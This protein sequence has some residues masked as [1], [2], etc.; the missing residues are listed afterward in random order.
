MSDVADTQELRGQKLYEALMALKPAELVETEWAI[1]A[2]LN[3]AFFTNLKA[4]D[5]S[6]RS[7][8]LAKLLA[9]IGK[10]QADLGMPASTAAPF[11]MEGASAA[12]MRADVPVYGTALGSDQIFDGEH[13][14]QTML[15]S[16]EVIGHLKRPVLLDGRADIYGVYV[17][18]S[19]MAP[20]FRDGETAF[21]EGKRPA[22]V[23]DDVVVYLVSPDREGEDQFH[24]VLIKTLVRK[25][26]SYIELEQYN[27]PITFKVDR[28]A[29]RQIDRVIPW[30]E[31]VA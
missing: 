6:P 2:G 7:D 29:V 18:G 30:S 28:K 16:D 24:A 5:T 4:K 12:R 8:N 21:V 14:E 22:S 9:Y 25:S 15:Y 11:R 1:N 3:R 13:I 20:R 27:P 26:A 19:S 23:G 17:Q 31:L 10:S